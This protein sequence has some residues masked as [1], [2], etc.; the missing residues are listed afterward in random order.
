MKI[1]KVAITRKIVAFE[2]RSFLIMYFSWKKRVRCQSFV[3]VKEGDR[4]EYGNA[5]VILASVGSTEK[6]HLK[7]CIDST[8]ITNKIAKMS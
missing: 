7:I 3:K 2:N 4:K 5:Y 1:W 8:V 6:L